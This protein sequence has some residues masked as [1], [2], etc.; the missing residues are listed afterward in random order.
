[1][2]GVQ[3]LALGASWT[4]ISEGDWSREF[5]IVRPL[6]MPASAL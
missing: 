1:V 6:E 4:E 3:L 5:L 2:A